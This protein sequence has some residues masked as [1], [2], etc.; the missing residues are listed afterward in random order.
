MA[1]PNVASFYG[2]LVAD[3]KSAYLYAHGSRGTLEDVLNNKGLELDWVFSLSFGLDAAE[4]M[5]YLHNKRIIHG[6]LSTATC[7]ITEK[8][9]LQIKGT[10]QQL[11]HCTCQLLHK[12]LVTVVLYTRLWLERT[13]QTVGCIL[14]N[15]FPRCRK[16]IK[17]T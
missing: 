12:K 17:G 16:E 14:R 10:A 3:T 1:H 7:V 9:A 4:G 13:S 5:A 15:D 8:W 11:L 2:C 6:R